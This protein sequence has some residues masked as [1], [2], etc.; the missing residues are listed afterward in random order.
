MWI[1]GK[2]GAQ[3]LSYLRARARWHRLTEPPMCLVERG[4]LALYMYLSAAATV[5]HGSSVGSV[6]AAPTDTE[7]GRAVEPAATGLESV[8]ESRDDLFNGLRVL[9][10]LPC[11]G[12]LVTAKS[13]DHGS[14]W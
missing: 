5:S 11:R 4:Y 1:A 7:R 12:E 6:T 14:S 10:K 13:S 9:V 8:L 2:G 3:V